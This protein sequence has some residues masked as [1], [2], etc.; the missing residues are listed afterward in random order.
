MEISLILDLAGVLE[1]LQEIG[2]HRA[3]GLFGEIGEIAGFRSH[4]SIVA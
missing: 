2:R 3:G 4:T 1:G